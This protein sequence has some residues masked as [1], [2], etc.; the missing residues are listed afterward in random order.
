[1]RTSATDDVHDDLDGKA[2]VLTQIEQRN[3]NAI[4]IAFISI[5]LGFWGGWSI[6]INDAGM[7]RERLIERDVRFRVEQRLALL[8]AEQEREI[9]SLVQAMPPGVYIYQKIPVRNEP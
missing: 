1:M 9:D 6:G 2:S 3:I 4:L 8:T 7:R 5:A